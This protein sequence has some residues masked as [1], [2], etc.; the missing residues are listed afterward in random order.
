MKFKTLI[1]EVQELTS[2]R[3]L[4][5]LVGK[6]DAAENS[7]R[8]APKDCLL[9][10]TNFDV[11]VHS[12]GWLYFLSAVV[13]S[14][15]R[16]TGNSLRLL[17][18]FFRGCN[19]EQMGYARHKCLTLAQ[20]FLAMASGANKGAGSSMALAR[21]IAIIQQ[22]RGTLTPLHVDFIK[23]CVL[24]RSYQA[25]VPVLEQSIVE[26]G[27]D[28]RNPELPTA[29]TNN[30]ISSGGDSNTNIDGVSGLD[31][32]RYFYYGGIVFLSLK[33][34]TDAR[35]MLQTCISLPTESLSSVIVE[36]YKKWVLCS[37]LLNGS[38][39]ELPK[40]ASPVISRHIE[41]AADLYVSFGKAFERAVRGEERKASGAAASASATSS[42]WDQPGSMSPHRPTSPSTSTSSRLKGMMSMS[43]RGGERSDKSV[44]SKSHKKKVPALH[45]FMD[46]QE[47]MFTH[48]LNWGLVKQCRKRVV[49]LRIQRLMDTYVGITFEQVSERAGL[50]KSSL[51]LAAAEG[52]K[53]VGDG[54]GVGGDMTE[55]WLL[56]MIREGGLAARIDAVKQTMEFIVEDGSGSIATA[57][58]AAMV[59]ELQKK[60]AAALQLA[61]KLQDADKDL[62]VS[63]LYL[64]KVVARESKG[65][66]PSD[67]AAAASSG[68]GGGVSSAELGEAGAWAGVMDTGF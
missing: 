65:A 17:N 40:Y 50:A 9:E 22:N 47:K 56:Q 41:E 13:N 24:S 66:V 23:L 62:S 32:M 21:A 2:T 42:S 7:L 44:L 25:A 38:M 18:T 12:L 67:A 1:A 15:D 27:F 52:F 37:L 4:E 60:I 61:E 33:R 49:H 51:V 46:N 45:E 20:T 48:D 14:R 57:G 28:A 39:P 19:A 64:R 59:Q 31:V 63:H 43:S 3:N 6:L 53:A 55:T 36:A 16:D 54:E 26:V 10:L 8:V 58:G 11:G 34:F 30:S 35:N 29:S 5:K 68:M